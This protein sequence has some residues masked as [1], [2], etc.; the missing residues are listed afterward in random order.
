MYEFSERV[1]LSARLAPWVRHQHVSRYA[2]ACEFARGAR[3]VDA[4]CGTGYGAWMLAHDGQAATV[5]AFD[6]SPAAI[7]EARGAYGAL[8]ALRFA[9]GDATKLPAA[10]RSCDLYVSFET[11]EHVADDRALVAEAARVLRP[12]GRFLCSTPNRRLF[13]PGRSLADKPH[14]PHHVREYTLSEFGALLAPHFADVDWLGQG[15]YPDGYADL[16][17]RIGRGWPRMALRMHQAQKACTLA[18]QGRARHWP[19][20]LVPGWQP[21][22]LIALA[23]CPG[24]A[25]DPRHG[26]TLA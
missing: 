24:Q 3:V 15:F 20:P 5:E 23:T 25:T 19:R 4:A 16:L 7:A 8:D 1:S 10:D 17:E 9:V 26:S 14:N 6:L 18:W 11:V 2:W 12:G 13:A 21:E 22:I